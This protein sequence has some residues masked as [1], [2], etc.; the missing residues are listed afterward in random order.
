MNPIK[1]YLNLH[2]VINLLQVHKVI[3]YYYQFSWDYILN[4]D[5][6]RNLN[7]EFIQ[8]SSNIAFGRNRSFWPCS[9]SITSFFNRRSLFL[10]FAK[11]NVF[12]K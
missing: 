8:H 7:K 4:W 9:R 11:I 1:G 12:Y 6:Y 2:D 5:E 10:F 3:I